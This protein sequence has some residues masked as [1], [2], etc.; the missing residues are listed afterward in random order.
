M[1]LGLTS[2]CPPVRSKDVAET[3]T[4]KAGPRRVPRSSVTSSNTS[5]CAKVK[6]GRLAVSTVWNEPAP[7]KAGAT[8][9][10]LGTPECR[11]VDEAT[12]GVIDPHA[13]APTSVAAARLWVGR[14]M[15]P[16]LVSHRRWAV[17][18]DGQVTRKVSVTF[19][20]GVHSNPRKAPY[21]PHFDSA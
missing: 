16:H 2:N 21:P 10:S 3:C 15:G 7:I 17:A 13:K 19:Q 6:P 9:P 1:L 8:L 20:V 14:G 4:S 5:S 12:A 18:R 11:T